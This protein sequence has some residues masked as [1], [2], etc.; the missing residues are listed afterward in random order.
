MEK[1]R[2]KVCDPSG[3][4][5]IAET[6]LKFGKVLFRVPYI[7]AVEKDNPDFAEKGIIEFTVPQNRY[8]KAKK[9]ITKYLEDLFLKELEKDEN[10]HPGNGNNSNNGRS[11]KVASSGNVE[12]TGRKDDNPVRDRG[13]GSKPSKS[14]GGRPSNSDVAESGNQE[15]SGES[16]KR[17]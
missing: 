4:V 8:A 17:D 1:T 9:R 12:K 16:E 11:K 10:I 15:S 13:R 5:V 3:K 2:L 7:K 6:E 14:G